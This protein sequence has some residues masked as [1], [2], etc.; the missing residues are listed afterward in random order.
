MIQ[1]YFFKIFIGCVCYYTKNILVGSKCHNCCISLETICNKTY[2]F[3]IEQFEKDCHRYLKCYFLVE[4]AIVIFYK[5]ITGEISRYM[6]NLEH[7]LT[8]R[9]R[10]GRRGQNLQ[11][12]PKN[13]FAKKGVP[14]GMCVM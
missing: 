13:H 5:V 6:Y 7:N 1:D 4:K 9:R 14:L 11:M 8:P 10:K 3:S 2:N 12:T